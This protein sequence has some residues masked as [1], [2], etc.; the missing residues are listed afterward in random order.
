MHTRRRFLTACGLAGAWLAIPTVVRAKSVVEISM[1]ASAR[2]EA[3]WFD[4]IGLRIAP[5]QMVRWVLHHDVHTTTAYHPKND[6]HSLRIPETAE[7]WDSG[8]LMT[9]GA[10]FEVTFSVEGV[11]DYFCGPHEAA[12]MVGRIVVGRPSGPGTLPFDYFKNQTGSASWKSVPDA[13]QAAL[14]SVAAI[15]KHGIVRRAGIGRT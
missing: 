2:G 8:F 1:R 6:N 4:P 15:L 10:S 12:G 11:Y 3:V 5:G 14:P 13:A 9:A 7:P